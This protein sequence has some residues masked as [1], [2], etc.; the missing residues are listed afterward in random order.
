MSLTDEVF[1]IIDRSANFGHYLNM[2]KRLLV[3]ILSFAAIICY[4]Y[5][6]G[7]IGAYAVGRAS[8]RAVLGGLAGGTF[9][10][11]AT[12]KLWRRYLDELEK[13]RNNSGP[14]QG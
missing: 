3:L 8:P 12:L 5:A 14:D 9:C 13:E 10:V 2:S 7:G 11:W 6:V 4:G 1:T